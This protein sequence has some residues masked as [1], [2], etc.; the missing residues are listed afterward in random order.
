MTKHRALTVA[1][2]GIAVLFFVAGIYAAAPDVVKLKKDYES[3]KGVVEFHHKKHAEDYTQQYPD[4]YPNKCGECHHDQDHK[5]LAD[6]SPDGPVKACIECH[7][8]PGEVPKEVKNEWRA[9]KIKKEEK[10]KL[11]LEYHAEA[12]HENCKRCH[13]AFNKKYKPKKA[14]TTCTQCHP[15]NK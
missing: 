10:Q 4:L 5:P 15:K 2:I 3:T 12:V 1:T 13:K 11:K 14:P 6:L 8:K 7:K 9:K